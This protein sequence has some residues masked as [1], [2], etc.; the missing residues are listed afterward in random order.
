MVAAIAACGAVY[1]VFLY[2][3][4]HPLA[5]GFAEKVRRDLMEGQALEDL[6]L[7]LE[8]DPA[9]SILKARA[10]VRFVLSQRRPHL[11]LRQLLF[12]LP[13]DLV[14]SLHP[15][16]T[17]DRVV[18]GDRKLTYR[19]IKSTV[20]V[21]LDGLPPED[22]CVDLDLYYTGQ[23]TGELGHSILTNNL[24][25]LDPD[26]CFYPRQG[27][28][29]CSVKVDF[30]LPR[31]LSVVR[32]SLGKGASG[33]AS[34]GQKIFSFP[35]AV[36]SFALAGCARRPLK[37]RIRGM[38]F[39]FYGWKQLDENLITTL[40][41][42][43]RF[44]EDRMPEPILGELRIIRT[45]RFLDRGIRYD[46]AGT[47]L[48]PHRITDEDIAYFLTL[49]WLESTEGGQGILFNREELAWGLALYFMDRHRSRTSY[50]G[51]LYEISDPPPS[52]PRSGAWDIRTSAPRFSKYFDT[53]GRGGYL[54]SVLRHKVGNYSFDR[55][56]RAML[57]LP[58][59]EDGQNWEQWDEVTQRI[60]GEELGWFFQH[61][62]H[63]GQELD[64]AVVDFSADDR[65]VGQQIRLVFRN[66][67]DLDLPDKVKVLFITETATLQES[68]TVSRSPTVYSSYVQDKVVGVV[69]DPDMEWLDSNRSNNTAYL[70]PSPYMAVPSENNRYL[71]VAYHKRPGSDGC[72]L[73]VYQTNGQV[74]KAYTLENPV[75]GMEWIS[76][77]RMI[78][79]APPR[80]KKGDHPPRESFQY[81][82][83]VPSGQFER[84]KPGVELSASDSGRYLLLNEKRGR[85]WRHKIRDLNRRTTR[86]ILNEV[87]FPLR[88]LPGT[89]FIIPD[90]PPNYGKDMIIYSRQGE[91]E[92]IF[93]ANSQYRLYGFHGFQEGLA[94]ILENEDSKVLY[95]LTDPEERPKP[96]VELKGEPMG[97]DD[98]E[99]GGVAFLKE[100]LPDD[101]MKVSRFDPIREMREV[102]FEGEADRAYDIFCHKGLLIKKARVDEEGRFCQDIYFHR[103]GEE[104]GK[105]ISH[106]VPP[107]RVLALVDNQRYLYYAEERRAPWSELAAFNRYLF[108]RYDFLSRETK[109]LEFVDL[110][111]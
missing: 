86:N 65:P 95:T 63:Q 17:I 48:V 84:L 94:F 110:Q 56:L 58:F 3:D 87:P 68:L 107:E 80:K 91:G 53:M 111:Y 99:I 104:E 23:P 75:I 6:D 101:M 57:M 106:S 41:E 71:A 9:L 8:L 109:R 72:P 61:W 19:H 54:L 34:A 83:D 51:N 76:D 10:S 96:L 27:D 11:L 36:A 73:I 90:Y 97:F 2:L 32:P 37:K 70:V 79:K 16:L 108:Y 50:L 77:N 85:R 55:I 28:M 52:V 31:G 35:R 44:L 25:Y 24:V 69:L 64:L 13:T 93:E 4:G 98:S 26:D 78:L 102:L 29:P 33:G 59:D 81:L 38:D 100:S 15:D 7:K 89:D 82:I 22:G 74:E 46:Q 92:Y 67:G 14:F 1:F 20:Y 103:F 49:F 18:W 62:V 40:D 5:E 39:V 105:Y 88:W 43:Q 47:I 45:P 66:N 30:D 60:S 21:D 42:V 12:F